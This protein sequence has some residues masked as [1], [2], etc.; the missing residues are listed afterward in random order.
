MLSEKAIPISSLPRHDRVGSIGFKFGGR[1]GA[2][3]LL[4]PRRHRRRGA[5]PGVFDGGV[6][7]GRVVI[8]GGT[9]GAFNLWM[10]G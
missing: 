6:G 9:F 8:E 3:K 2:Q 10:N 4:R 7:G 5:P 1:N